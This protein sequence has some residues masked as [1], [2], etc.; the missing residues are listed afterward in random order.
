MA[1]TATSAFSLTEGIVWAL[2]ISMKNDQPQKE[3]GYDE[4]Y[5]AY[6]DA[7][8]ALLTIDPGDSTAVAKAKAEAYYNA[9]RDAYYDVREALSKP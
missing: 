1:R 6:I 2:D 4:A 5:H 3:Y 7:Y 9:M 8:H